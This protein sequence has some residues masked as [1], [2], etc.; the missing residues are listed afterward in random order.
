MLV[1]SR[2]TPWW[3]SLPVLTAAYLGAVWLRLRLVVEPEQIAVF[4]PASGLALGVLLAGP[5]VGPACLS[6]V[7]LAEADRLRWRSLT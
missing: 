5:G 7:A 4:W 1:G 2:S 6:A 3:L